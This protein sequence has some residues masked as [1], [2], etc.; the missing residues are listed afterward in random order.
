M[1]TPPSKHFRLDP[2]SERD[3]S[4]SII[5]AMWHS[6][7]NLGNNCECQILYPLDESSSYVATNML[8]SDLHNET[9]TMEPVSDDSNLIIMTMTAEDGRSDEV[10]VR[11]SNGDEEL[12][13][14][15]K[16]L[17]GNYCAYAA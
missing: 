7:D 5:S 6:D 10:T 17:V 4:D 15:G 16:L 9:D 14:I 8:D 12:D 1:A 11:T 2:S 3:E 13:K